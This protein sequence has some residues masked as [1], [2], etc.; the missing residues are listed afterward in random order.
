MFCMNCIASLIATSSRNE[1]HLHA[2]YTY[3]QHWV[4]ATKKRALSN[5]ILSPFSSIEMSHDGCRISR[6][7]SHWH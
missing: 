4:N 7:L 3:L 2:T 6:M 5:F 1:Q